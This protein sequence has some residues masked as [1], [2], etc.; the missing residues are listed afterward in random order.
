MSKSRIEIL[1]EKSN[2]ILE[3]ESMTADSINIKCI[4]CEKQFQRAHSAPVQ[5]HLESSL[6]SFN[7]IASKKMAATDET[8]QM[9][10]TQGEQQKKKI[11]E[12]RKRI[13]ELNLENSDAY[14]TRDGAL[15]Y[16]CGT[17]HEL[18]EVVDDTN[19]IDIHVSSAQHKEHFVHE[20]GYTAKEFDELVVKAFVAMNKPIDSIE[21]NI[22]NEFFEEDITHQISKQ[23]LPIQIAKIK[24]YCRKRYCRSSL[25]GK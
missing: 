6:H 4:P 11:A 17:C 9:T 19:V 5:Q 18:I 23:F 15:F 1:V 10:N 12:M 21:K 7:V 25:L 3:I 2:G 13:E 16:S 14:R 8:T 24:S 22:I 20:D